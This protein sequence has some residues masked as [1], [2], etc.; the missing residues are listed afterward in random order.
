[1]FHILLKANEIV[2]PWWSR[3]RDEALRAYWKRTD[4]LS[5]AVFSFLSKITSI[6]YS[7]TARNSM[8]KSHVVSAEQWN[9]KL[10]YASDLGNGWM[11]F[12]SRW[13][14]DFICT[15]NGAFA[16]II[17]PGKIDGPITGEVIGIANLDSLRCIRTNNMEFPVIYIDPKGAR[18][19]LHYTSVMF[20]SQLPSADE[21]MNGT[22]FCSVSRAIYT[23]QTLLD[24]NIF[25]QEK[26]GSRPHRGLVLVGGGLD[27]GYVTRSLEVANQ[28]ADSGGY[29]R[30]RPMTVIGDANVDNPTV[31]VVDTN[32]VPDGFDYK[33]SMELGMAIIAL[34]FGVDAKELFPISGGGATRADALIQ[35][36]KQRG[37]GPG[38]T[39]AML[40]NL[41]NMKVMPPYLKFEFDYQDDA[42]DRQV[43]EINRIRSDSRQRNVDI[44]VTT[45]RT[46]REL[47]VKNGEISKEQ[48][49]EMELES[50]RLV[51]G[52]PTLSLFGSSEKFFMTALAIEGFVD[53][54]DAENND[55]KLITMAIKKRSNELVKLLSSENAKLIMMTKQAL[56]ALE[57][58]KVLYEGTTDIETESQ[59]VEDFDNVDPLTPQDDENNAMQDNMNVK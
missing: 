31:A 5:G 27:P 59:P 19:K 54:M 47:M 14:E 55:K 48:F 32:S 4:Q 40:E 37:K 18:H 16:E 15:D 9:Q 26:L 53:P 36:I 17:G 6:P 35:H 39:I 44:G 30:Y 3:S 33:E 20:A 52:S 25:Q 2:P 51:D 8:I 22:G 42:Q 23:S 56:S 58:L 41:M 1:L 10:E 45:I 38:Y 43:A 46:E 12:L 28:M 29:Q 49:F 21:T 13:V 34:A 11:Y 50:G 57:Q 7:I 24:Q